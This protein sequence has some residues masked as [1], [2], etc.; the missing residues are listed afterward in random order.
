MILDSFKTKEKILLKFLKICDFDSWSEDSLQKAVEEC[1][2]SKD[3]IPLIFEDSI[4]S[5]SE[6][7]IEYQNQKA[8]ENIAKIKDFDHKKIR[9]K[10]RLCLYERFKVEKKYKT[11]LNR[12]NNFYLNPKNFCSKNGPKPAIQGLKLCFS[13]ADFMWKT[14]KDSSTDFN[15]YTKR[16]TLSK[17][18]L[19]TLRK[20][21]KSEDENMQDVKDFIDKEIEA[22]MKFEKRKAQIKSFSQKLADNS[23]KIIFTEDGSLNEPKNIIKKLPFFRLIKF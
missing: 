1:D 13:I 7:Y 12:L 18:I 16:L 21:I 2:I 20:F 22:V 19:K 17:I 15:Y 11:Q 4:L 5:L 8:A 3:S 10:I 9:D 6:F 23:H 14:I